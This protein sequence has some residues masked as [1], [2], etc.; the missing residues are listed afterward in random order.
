MTTKSITYSS[1]RGCPTQKHISFR[2]A[3]MRG[4]AH[5]RGLFIPD[6]F[7]TVSTAELESWRDLQYHE[8]ATEVIGK[9]VGEDEVPRD[10][11]A[12]IVK[13]SCGAFRSEEVTPLIKIDGHY[14]L[15]SVML[16]RGCVYR[17]MR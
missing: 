5:D 4:L 6:S 17:H 14:I 9:F 2:S 12:D 13:R 3:V 15:V 11:L 8:L 16:S 7:P 10:V 1:T